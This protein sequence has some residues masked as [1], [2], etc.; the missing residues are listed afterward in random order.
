MIPASYALFPS[1][2]HFLN[3]PPVHK[4]SCLPCFI[5][6]IVCCFTF[7]LLSHLSF[8][9]CFGHPNSDL[10]NFLFFILLVCFELNSCIFG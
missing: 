9:S 5:C 6:L 10:I 4:Q 1:Y 7:P 3:Q 8:P 2:L